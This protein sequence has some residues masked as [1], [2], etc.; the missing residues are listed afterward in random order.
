MSTDIQIS[1]AQEKFIGP[2]G[3]EWTITPPNYDTIRDYTNLLE[4]LA[5][6]SLVRNKAAYG[7]EYKEARTE[8]ALRSA[9]GAFEWGGPVFQESLNIDDRCF[10]LALMTF[11]QANPAITRDE[12]RGMWRMPD[13]IQDENG[14]EQ[15]GIRG[16]NIIMAIL[17]LAF[18]PN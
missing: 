11:K 12:L 15:D 8:L 3:R 16:S 10:E 6:E 7:R 14:K 2:D 5:I 1:L 9:A 13:K 18:R 4:K 17:R